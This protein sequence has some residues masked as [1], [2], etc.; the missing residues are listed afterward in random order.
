MNQ[1]AAQ[2]PQ[3]SWSPL[4]GCSKD[5]FQKLL[6]RQHQPATGMW[7]FS[8]VATTPK[9]KGLHMRPGKLSPKDLGV[10]WPHGKK[11]SLFGSLRERKP[12]TTTTCGGEGKR[13]RERDSITKYYQHIQ[14]LTLFRHHLKPF[15][16]LGFLSEVCLEQVSLL[17]HEGKVVTDGRERCCWIT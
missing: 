12:S 3:L 15:K 7:S 8:F 11:K 6:C 17:S 4:M 13:R 16:F 14:R 1:A 2:S 5:H 10:W 9:P